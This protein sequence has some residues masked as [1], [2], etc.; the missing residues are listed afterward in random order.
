ML[1]D[2]M[3]AFLKTEKTTLESL[4]QQLA[5]KQ[6]EEGKF[7]HAMMDFNLSGDSDAILRSRTRLEE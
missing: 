4:T 2:P 3:D 7:S 5:V 1:R 6:N